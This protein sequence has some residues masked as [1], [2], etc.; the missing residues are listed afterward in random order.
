MLIQRLAVSLGVLLLFPGGAC[1]AG[2]YSPAEQD[3]E[4]LFV[5][6]RSFRDTYL[7]FKNA[8][9]D[10]L[11][12]PLRR[13][14]LLVS[15]LVPAFNAKAATEPQLL[16]VSA[17]LVRLAQYGEAITLLKDGVEK[18]PDNFFLHANLGTA[19]F[20]KSGSADEN[21]IRLALNHLDESRELWPAK[22]TELNN[23]QLQAVEDMGWQGEVSP[24]LVASTEGLLASRPDLGPW[25]AISALVPGRSKWPRYNFLRTV[26]KYEYRLVSLRRTRKAG[27]DPIFASKSGVP[28]HFVGPS[29]RYE[30]GKLDPR[31]MEKL[32]GHSLKE[33]I[34]IVEQLLIWMPLDERLYWLLGELVNA[35]GQPEDALEIFTTL[36]KNKFSNPDFDDHRKVLEEYVR[37]PGEATGSKIPSPKATPTKEPVA[38]EDTGAENWADRWRFFGVGLGVGVVLA[39]F[40]AWQVRR[41]WR[42]PQTS[43]RLGSATENPV[44]LSRLH[45]ERQR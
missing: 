11:D 17:Y 31:E 29:G 13:R 27:L 7:Y 23:E 3:Q 19:Y 14:A 16:D 26:A 32:P 15:S 38:P 33:A 12:N 20:L 44:S 28:V 34:L 9:N 25:L 37:K 42:R 1:W 22:F 21:L 30:A 39:L 8:L 18:F 45:E 2:L 43:R 4:K 6:Y 41:F 5:D 24:E 10:T 35:D 36:N 40:A